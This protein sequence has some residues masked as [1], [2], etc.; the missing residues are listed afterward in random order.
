MAQQRNIDVNSIRS[1]PMKAI[2]MAA[3]LVMGAIPTANAVQCYQ[4]KATVK[5]SAPANMCTPKE[6]GYANTGKGPLTHAGC[7][8][9]KNQA[10]GKLRPRLQQS[11]RAYV[12][13]NEPC[14]VIELP[15]CT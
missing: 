13:T 4:G 15:A 7:T 10:A 9:A 2:F 12:Q 3:V 14:T 1:T 6:K 8:A 5:Q 11:C